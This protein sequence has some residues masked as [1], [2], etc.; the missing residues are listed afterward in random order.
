M[1]LPTIASIVVSTSM[2]GACASKPE[3]DDAPSTVRPAIL[4]DINAHN[5]RV[6]QTL[7]VMM[8][9]ECG[10]G[11]LPLPMYDDM[12]DQE[13]DIEA[14]REAVSALEHTLSC[15]QDS[16]KK[17]ISLR[18]ET[19]ENVALS[20]SD[21]LSEADAQGLSHLMLNMPKIEDEISSVRSHNMVISNVLADLQAHI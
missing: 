8:I 15:R 14:V 5:K 6:S 11:P 13:H 20:A 1:R 21:I 10:K 4:E 18:K 19:L 16:Y 2:L 7:D 9:Y 12:L 17:V 3:V